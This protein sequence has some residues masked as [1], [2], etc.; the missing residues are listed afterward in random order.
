MSLLARHELREMIE[1]PGSWC[2][3][4][5]MPAHRAGAETQ[6]DPIRL[7]NLLNE[8]EAKLLAA[9][10]PSPVARD[11]L[12]PGRRLLDDSAFWRHQGDGLALFLAS[13]T[14][15]HYRLPLRFDSLVVA[16]PRFHIKP[17]LPLLTADDE[18]YILA[19]SQGE[20]RL[21]HGTRYCVSEVDVATMPNGLSDALKYDDPEKQLQFHTGTA[22]PGTGLRAPI[23]HGHAVGVNDTKPNLL[24]YFRT[25]DASLHPVLREEQ[26]PL[27]LAGVDYLLP[28]YREA[29]TYPHL[30]DVEITGSPENLSLRALHAQA[31]ELLRP[32]FDAAREQARSRYRQLTGSGSSQASSNLRDVLPAAH[33]GRVES[34]FVALGLQRWGSFSP[35]DR[36]VE[37][38]EVAETGDVDLLDLAAV[39]TFVNRGVAYPLRPDEMPDGAEAAAVFRYERT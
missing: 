5:Y 21:L 23:Y 17:L 29:N 33:A 15:R 34:L 31:W 20:V 27:V 35:V 38:H 2:V 4:I 1:F 37:I 32:H 39:H 28:I 18:F 26:A 11:V 9:G 30:A 16:A 8:A 10:L 19:L 24:R 22:A 12:D 25:V 36:S 3:S 14:S 6:Q 13:E 7:R